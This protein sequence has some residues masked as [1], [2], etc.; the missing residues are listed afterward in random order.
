MR[1]YSS[2]AFWL[3]SRIFEAPIVPG[4][5]AGVLAVTVQQLSRVAEARQALVDEGFRMFRTRLF[6]CLG[7]L[8]QC[9]AR[10]TRRLQA[11][12]EFLSSLAAWGKRLEG[13]AVTP[14]REEGFASRV[15]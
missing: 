2:K 7:F 15:P 9:L 5:S 4:E 11:A 6:A 10:E 12:M 1:G 14:G 13:L 3:E 8:G